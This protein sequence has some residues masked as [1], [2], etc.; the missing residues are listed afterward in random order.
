MKKLLLAV[1]V[2]AL[3]VTSAFAADLAPA[4][5]EPAAPAYIPYSWTGF[6]LGAQAGYGWSNSDLT[7]IN[8]DGSLAGKSSANGDGAFGGGFAGYN[9]QFDGGF[10]IGAEADINGGE[11]KSGRE[12]IIVP[13]F[14]VAP[15]NSAFSKMDWFG[16][17]RLRLGYA[18]DRFLPFVTGGYA[19]GDQ[20]AGFTGITAASTSDT[21]SGWTVGAGLEYAIT[22]HILA[23]VEYRY[24]DYGSKRAGVVTNVGTTGFIDRDFKTNDVRV[25]V[26]YKF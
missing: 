15:A 19:F 24:S 1:S 4:P 23:R 2:V 20:K 21:L 26:S 11:I 25:G 17:A 16:S 3:T 13:G 9:Y 12:A 22:D 8:P 5:V 18:F 10:V 6:Y 7:F 14:G